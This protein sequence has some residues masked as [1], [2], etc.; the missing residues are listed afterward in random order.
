MSEV[1]LHSLWIF[2]QTEEGETSF[3]SGREMGFET[4]IDRDVGYF[5]PVHNRA[6]SMF[7]VA[8]RERVVFNF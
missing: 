6:S 8:V 4:C 2:T 5:A 7:R 1:R 3:A